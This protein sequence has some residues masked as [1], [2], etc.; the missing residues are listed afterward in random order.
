MAEQASCLINVAYADERPAGLPVALGVPFPKGALTDSSLVSVSAPSGER[1]P[2]ACRPFVKWPDGSSRWGLVAFGAR[3]TGD[4]ELTLDGA[5][6][7]PEQ[8]VTLTQDGDAWTID[9]GRLRVTLCETGPGIIHR[10]ECNGHTYLDDPSKLALCV[11]D[12]TTRHEAQRSIRVLENSPLRVRMRVEGAHYTPKGE[13]RLSYRLDVEL[14]T[15]WTTLRLDYHFFHLEPGRPGVK[16]DRLACDTEWLLSEPTERHFLQREYGLFYVSRQVFNPNPVAIVADS[17]REPAHVTDPAMLLDDVDYPFYLH[18][19]L[20]NTQTW[21]GTGDQTHAVYAQM[22]DF[23]LARPNHLASEAN[24]LSVEIWPATAGPLDLPQGRSKRHTILLSFVRR[25]AQSPG[26]AN[27][28]L[29][30]APH[31]APAGVAAA[32]GALAY[33]E[34]A[35]VC[36]DWL[37]QCGEF[38]QD[39]VLPAGQHVRIESNLA[40]LM[41][42][43]M[44]HTKFDVGD[45]DSHYSASYAASSDEL[46]R[47]I[48][49]APDI[50]RIW[51]GAGPTQTYVDLHEP[52]WTNNEYDVIHAFANEIM[53]TG[54]HGL[55]RTLRLTARHNI[56]VDF[57]HYSDHQWLHRATPAH[58]AR[59]TT[60]G[61]YPS[62]FWTQGLLEYYCLT[63]DVDGLEVAL[64]L[65]DKTIECFADPDNREVLW[66]FN[67]EVGWTVLA[68]V[69]LYDITREERFK[70]L[71]DEIVDYLIA[72]D[73]DGFTGAVNLSG[74]NDRQSLNRQILGNFFGYQSMIDGV[75]RYATVTNRT[76][77]IAWLTKLCYDLADASL[78]AAREGELPDTRFGLALAVG[79]ERT[80]DDRFLK[81][82]SLVLDQVFW[83]GRGLG[84]GGRVKPVASAYRG[85][86]R[87]LGHANRHGLLDA[88]EY[89]SLRKLRD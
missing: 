29:S 15:G 1:R 35:T 89:P 53:R 25:E 27:A 75:D 63:G 72:F 55:L 79:Y 84:G 11:D 37:A 3:E 13:R 48:P 24:R 19:P 14:W 20:V 49:G 22:D 87:M 66:G 26:K 78:Q 52:V 77:V 50:P 6:P 18:A 28:K 73:R 70:P 4:H 21:L 65:G 62:H 56:E 61:A 85:W 76:D 12:A 32:L 64:A 8:P 69:H 17:T 39:Q 34:R 36:P 23:L 58:S 38:E 83:N 71:L 81:L 57:L 10:V 47:P 31:Q 7:A 43:D 44:P 2:T 59:H 88:Y 68:L 33:D 60:T 42:L 16:I 41:H 30:N 45:T 82:M 40:G 74:G 67:R 9:N 5:S 54:R 51:H 46:V 86:T 80:G